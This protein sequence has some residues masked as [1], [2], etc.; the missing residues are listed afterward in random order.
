MPA[1]ADEIRSLYADAVNDLAGFLTGTDFQRARAANLLTQVDQIMG[2]LGKRV[3]PLIDQAVEE[4]YRKGLSATDNDLRK[5]G[6]SAGQ[7]PIKGQFDRINERSIEVIAAD[8]RRDLLSATKE[9]GDRARRVI[10]RTAQT[11]VR[12]EDVSRAIAKGLIVGGNARRVA[13]DLRLKFAAGEAQ[14]LLAAGAITATEAQEMADLA[15]GFIQ[16]GKVKMR[17]ATYA[18]MV[19]VTRLA[20]AVTIATEDRI[21][22]AGFDLVMITG[23]DTD[24]FCNYYVGRVFSISGDDDNYPALSEIVGQG[25]PFHPRCT[26]GEAP[27]IPQYATDAELKRAA[28][29]D[30]RLVGVDAKEATA[31]FKEDVED[32]DKPRVR[33]VAGM[34]AAK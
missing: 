6:V 19:A 1:A 21:Q 34:N 12:N 22:Q 5:I 20:E 30:E 18:E 10:R 16:A 17:I 9:L 13:R 27:F 26:H 33:E 24:D 2:R 29:V 14:R 4:Q 28:G 3:I 8:M 23:P 31:I 25:A 11:A 32:G 15:D 7:L